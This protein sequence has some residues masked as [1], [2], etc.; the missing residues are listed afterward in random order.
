[1][2]AQQCRLGP[3]GAPL[4]NRPLAARRRCPPHDDHLYRL[5]SVART[6][7]EANLEAH[8]AGR[9]VLKPEPLNLASGGRFNP[10]TA[11]SD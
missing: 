11:E 6:H 7:Y 10:P 1:M 2:V 9:E 5:L 4:Y 3:G 8:E